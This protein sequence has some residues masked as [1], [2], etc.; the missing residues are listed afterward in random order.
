MGLDGFD[1]ESGQKKDTLIYPI[2]FYTNIGFR[3]AA[4]LAFIN[5]GKNEL[6]YNCFNEILLVCMED[7]KKRIKI[8]QEDYNEFNLHYWEPILFSDE[9]GG[10]SYNK[11]LK[12]WVGN[13]L[14]FHQVQR[15]HRIFEEKDTIQDH[16]KV[17][18]N[19]FSTLGGKIVSSLQQH[20]YSK[21]R[22]RSLKALKRV[23]VRLELSI[24]Q[25]IEDKG[26]DLGQWNQV[27]VSPV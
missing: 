1:L 14:S 16:V 13:T 22:S 12:R 26:V 19:G 8:N 3:L 27:G 7:P 4:Y 5:Q 17:R 20:E 11:D 23:A 6:A 25:V 21:L 9:V 2:D 15:I 10:V 18:I 24:H